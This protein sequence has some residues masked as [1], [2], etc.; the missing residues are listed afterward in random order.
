MRHETT[1]QREWSVKTYRIL[2]KGNLTDCW[3][4]IIKQLPPNTYLNSWELRNTAAGVK[5]STPEVYAEV[6]I[7]AD[8]LAPWE[9]FNDGLHD[10][11]FPAGTLLHFSE[12]TS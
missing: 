7:P 1:A 5:L 6:S 10:A 2:V 12:I 9:W 11:P 4:A 8:S 3:E